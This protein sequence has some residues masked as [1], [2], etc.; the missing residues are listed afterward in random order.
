[1]TIPFNWITT[2]D[3]SQRINHLINLKDNWDGYGGICFS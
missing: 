3:L 2:T 1:M